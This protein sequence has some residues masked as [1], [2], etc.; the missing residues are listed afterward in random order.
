M[1]MLR[2]DGY[3]DIRAKLAQK[4]EDDDRFD[5]RGSIHESDLGSP[6]PT[7]SKRAKRKRASLEIR[8]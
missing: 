4:E 5:I 3:L 1:D 7:I 6:I 8:V 2:D